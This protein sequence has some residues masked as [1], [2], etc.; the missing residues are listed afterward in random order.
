MSESITVSILIP[1]YNYRIYQLVKSLF[2][3]ATSLLLPF[4]ILCFDDGSTITEFKKNNSKVSELDGVKYLELNEN[5]GRSRIRNK[6]AQE[7]QYDFLL[8][9]DC[10]SKII[11]E[12]YLKN[13]IESVK[14][15]PVILG[16]TVYTQ[17]S[18]PECSLRLKYGK[19]REQK[20]ALLRMKQPY[21]YIN[22]NN[23]FIKKEIYLQ[24]RLDEKIST[25]GHED[26]KF[27]YSLKEKKIPVFHID[28]PVDHCG[29]ESNAVFINKT[30]EGIKNF[31][32]ITLEGYGRD[33]KLFKTY[34]FIKNLRLSIL[35]NLYYTFLQEKI[36]RN[37]L[38]SNP[39]LF[40]FDLFKLRTLLDQKN[41]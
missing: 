21:H 4:E 14:T 2:N 34:F 37:L 24:N 25:Y 33:T 36:D 19:Q 7:A 10:D 6:L 5:I 26:T 13:Y 18:N 38:S 39:S 11:S 40:Y 8:F 16:G 41:S 23:L 27:G 35:F 12:S 1:V 15:N 28:N 32:N 29:L 31:Y 3:Q 30:K 20:S 17:S 9:I 22:L